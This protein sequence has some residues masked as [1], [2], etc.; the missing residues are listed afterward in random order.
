MPAPVAD[1]TDPRRPATAVAAATTD[2][3]TATA[4]AGGTQGPRALRPLLATVLDALA[5][6]AVDR[7]GPLP[8]GGP[9]PVAARVRAA[10]GPVIPET[11]TGATEALHA[12]VRVLA[13]GAAD[14]ADPHCAAHL[15][16]PPL[17]V[18]AAADLAAS[19]LNPS[20]DS[21]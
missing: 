19:A 1:P 20:M 8:A 4:L 3:P 16:C 14:P 21:W 15:H 2:P 10:V 13:A 5:T 11:G 12:L 6:G 7:A 9:A 17:A 18:A